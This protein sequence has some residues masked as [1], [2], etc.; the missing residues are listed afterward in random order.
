MWRYLLVLYVALDALELLQVFES[1]HLNIHCLNHIITLPLAL[2]NNIKVVYY[3]FV[4][5]N[6]WSSP[7]LIV[8][9]DQF[10]EAMRLLR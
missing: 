9:R 2:I 6:Q 10:D 5:G 3:G 4:I 1:G 8:I 7:G